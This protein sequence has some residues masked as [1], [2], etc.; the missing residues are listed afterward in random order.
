MR[1]HSNGVVSSVEG[2]EL[3]LEHDVAVDLEGRGRGLETTEAGYRT[4]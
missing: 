4:H 3:R 1:S 2:D